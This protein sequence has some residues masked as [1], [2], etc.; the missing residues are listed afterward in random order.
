M[1]VEKVQS[2][3]LFWVITDFNFLSE[4]INEQ[5]RKRKSVSRMTRK[6]KP[7]VDTKLTGT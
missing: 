4:P 1:I 7:K 5:K 3:F 2:P 6:G